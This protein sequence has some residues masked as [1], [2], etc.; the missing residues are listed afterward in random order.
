MRLRDGWPSR[1][2]EESSAEHPWY[3]EQAGRE[4]RLGRGAENFFPRQRRTRLV[5]SQRRG[6]R[7]RMGRGRDTRD[8][9]VL[10]LFGIGED[11]SQ[12][13]REQIQLL[14]GDREP[15][16]LGDPG[17]VFRAEDRGH[18]QAWYHGLSA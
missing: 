10:Q 17:D 13:A 12:L 2:P 11:A 14:A 15:R 7:E 8:I 1:W 3:F 9:D 18:S 6:E 16:E 5:I 4:I